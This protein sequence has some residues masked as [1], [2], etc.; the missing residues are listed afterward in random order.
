MNTPESTTFAPVTIAPVV[1]PNFKRN[2]NPN[3]NPN[4]NINLYPTPN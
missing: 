3:P 4:P 1:N 2:P